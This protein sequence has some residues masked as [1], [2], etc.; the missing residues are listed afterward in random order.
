MA[1]RSASAASDPAME[2]IV[3]SSTRL[4]RGCRC[5]GA[6]SMRA[7]DISWSSM[8]LRIFPVVPGTRAV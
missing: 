6:K 8:G 4:I 5:R 2:A 1:T 3:A 7:Y